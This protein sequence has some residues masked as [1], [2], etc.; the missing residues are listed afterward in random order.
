[1]FKDGICEEGK[2]KN[3]VLILLGKK[4]KLFLI[5][6]LKLKERVENVVVL[7]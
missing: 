4:Y 6:I 3:N 1:M 2:Y 5:W 7:V